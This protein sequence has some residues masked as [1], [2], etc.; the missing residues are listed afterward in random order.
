[1]NKKKVIQGFKK[2]F[3]GIGICFVAPVIIMQAFKNEGHTMYWPV[4]TVGLILLF[5]AITFGFIGISTLV[6]GLLGE[7]KKKQ[8]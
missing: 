5:L 8:D 7:K 1:M 2:V 4:L 3:W 6:G